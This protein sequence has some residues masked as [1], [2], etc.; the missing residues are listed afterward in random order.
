MCNG[1]CVPPLVQAENGNP[2]FIR[3]FILCTTLYHP[4][5]ALYRVPHRNIYISYSFTR[6][7][8]YRVV[9]GNPAFSYKGFLLYHPSK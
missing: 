4:N 5:Q 1:I 2:Y 8:W 7:R 9:H 3:V 6:K